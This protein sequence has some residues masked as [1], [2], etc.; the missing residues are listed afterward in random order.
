MCVWISGIN[1]AAIG[2]SIAERKVVLFMYGADEEKKHKCNSHL[3][4][5]VEM[6][7]NRVKHPSH[8]KRNLKYRIEIIKNSYE[9]I[10]G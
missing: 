6:I 1:F 10:R 8:Q 4:F 3:T 5:V 7:R 2:N 9:Y